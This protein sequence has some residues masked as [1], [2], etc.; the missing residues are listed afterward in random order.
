M[1]LVMSMEE[2]FRKNIA[3]IKSSLSRLLP[4]PAT[5]PKPFLFSQHV[6]LQQSYPLSYPLS[7]PQSYPQTPKYPQ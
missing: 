4:V 5:L 7:H 3:D 6:S 1:G 2:D